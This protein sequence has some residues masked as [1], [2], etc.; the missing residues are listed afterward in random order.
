VAILNDMDFEKWGTRVSAL[1][2]RL[3]VPAAYSRMVMPK[4]VPQFGAV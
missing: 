4:P 3:L 1:G 2:Y